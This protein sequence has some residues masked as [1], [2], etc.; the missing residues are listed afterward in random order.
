[1]IDIGKKN[2]LGVNINAIDYEAAVGHFVDAA[3]QSKRLTVTALAVHGGLPL[4]FMA[5]KA[6]PLRSCVRTLRQSFLTS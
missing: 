5:L 6:K 2:L 1:M 3:K 4:C